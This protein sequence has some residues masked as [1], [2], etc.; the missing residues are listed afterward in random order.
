MKKLLILAISV[1]GIGRV[2]AMDNSRVFSMFE[3]RS[4]FNA[5]PLSTVIDVQ[6]N[7]LTA[8][9]ICEGLVPTPADGTIQFPPEL[10]VKDRVLAVITEAVVLGNLNK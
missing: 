4:Y 5:A 3:A 2:Y 8:L 7:I 9:L 6:R 1:L 10:V